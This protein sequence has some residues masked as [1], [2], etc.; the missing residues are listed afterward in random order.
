MN[1]SVHLSLSIIELRKAVM[2]EFWHNRLNPKY[3]EIAK[4]YNM[5]TDSFI[6]HVKTDD[7]YKDITKDFETW[8]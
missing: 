6:V 7:N 5:D 3:W 4:L 8:F 2:C 1:K